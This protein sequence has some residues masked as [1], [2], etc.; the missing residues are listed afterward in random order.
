VGFLYDWHQQIHTSIKIMATIKIDNK[1][2]DLDT[3]SEECKAQLA[4]IQFVEQEL[5]RLQAQTAVLQTA[6]AAYLQGLKASL[7]V[8]GG[9]DTIK[10]S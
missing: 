2:Y 9:S 10:L 1:E 5:A 8:V 7:P 4:S 6:K 3:L